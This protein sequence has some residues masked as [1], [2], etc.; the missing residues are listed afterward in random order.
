VCHDEI[1]RE[2]FKDGIVK[3]YD[4]FS[5]VH[6]LTAPDPNYPFIHLLAAFA[7]VANL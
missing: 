2:I 3:A 7:N 5:M 4:G 6:I 1:S